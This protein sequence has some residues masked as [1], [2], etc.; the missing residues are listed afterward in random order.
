MPTRFVLIVA[1]LAVAAAALLARQ[2]PEPAPFAAAGAGSGTAAPARPVIDAHTRYLFDVHDHGPEEFTALLRRAGE[3][4]AAGGTGGGARVA[5]VLH[6]PDIELFARR[7]Y[8]RYEAIV[9]LAAA[10]EQR[11]VID[12]KACQTAA[13]SHGLEDTDLPEFIDMVPYG[14]DELE[15]L[16]RAGYVE[17]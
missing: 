9:D 10:L 13:R 5:V 16:R 8:Q 1:L 2:T 17:L 6:G 15:R 14:P 4:A 7:N 11:E 12:F 3:L